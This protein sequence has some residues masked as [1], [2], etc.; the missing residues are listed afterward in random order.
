MQER[1]RR[2]HNLQKVLPGVRLR[3]FSDQFVQIDDDACKQQQCLEERA[4]LRA[5]PIARS[6]WFDVRRE[7]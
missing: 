3:R 5:I 4:I 2:E 1:I 6:D 7:A